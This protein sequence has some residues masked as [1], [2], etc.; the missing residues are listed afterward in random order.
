MAIYEHKRLLTAIYH[1]QRVV[2]YA[3]KKGRLIYEYI[4][5]YL[6]TNDGYAL[7]CNDDYILKCND[8]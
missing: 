7:K 3:Y 2:L 1:S 8:Q 4:T 6:F 5:G